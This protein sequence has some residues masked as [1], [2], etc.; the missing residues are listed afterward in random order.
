M[1][2]A[3]YKPHSADILLKIEPSR[4]SILPYV[5]GLGFGLLLIFFSIRFD[6]KFN[7]L[8]YYLVLM[9]IILY[10]I[11]DHSYRQKNNI[12][13]IELEEKSLNVYKGKKMHMDS[14]LLSKVIEVRTKKRFL[15]RS[16]TLLIESVVW[17]KL[18][19]YTINSDHI[20]NSELLKL[21]EEIKKLRDQS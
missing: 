19:T 20:R 17:E 21:S 3:N 10:L 5:L 7:S 11:I 9:V 18:I 4:S 15:N 2:R 1:S 12:R 16:V 14:F 6:V 8:Y 13:L